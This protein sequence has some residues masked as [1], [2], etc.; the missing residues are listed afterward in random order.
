MAS[1]AIY[2]SAT[3][4]LSW[5]EYGGRLQSWSQIMGREMGA[6]A[7]LLAACGVLMVA[8]L[9]GWRSLRQTEAH[10]RV[11]WAFALLYALTLF[12]LLPITVDL[13]N[14]LT[15]AHQ[16]TDVGA[17]PL[18]DAPLEAASDPLVQAYASNYALDP[19]VYGPAWTILSTPATL[20]RHDVVGG[21]VYLKALA[22]LAFLGGSWLLERILR[23]L[24]PAE[25]LRGVYLFA[26]N[27]LVVLTAVG[28]GHNDIVMMALLLLATYLLL[29]ERWV[30]A[31]ALLAV[32]VWIKY[33]SAVLLPIFGLYAWRQI[34]RRQREARWPTVLQTGGAMA[35]VTA[36]A[37]LPFWS[38]EAFSGLVQRLLNPDNVAAGSFGFAVPALVLGLVLYAAVYLV[39]LW[40]LARGQG[41]L[42]E[43][44]HGGFV[45]LLLA[46]LF[47]AAR[48]QPWHLI[49]PASLAGL[50]DRRWAWPV[51]AGLAAVML[52]VQVWVEWGTPG[53]QM[54]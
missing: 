50:S 4:R 6:F 24:R 11:V 52:V 45:A 54:R 15:Q 13:F 43:T 20:G 44:L 21:L 18:V 30:W 35:L 29:R 47:G 37:F 34:G 46:F 10:R 36:A 7:L 53:L 33:M 1:E 9:V 12:W 51:V 23:Q 3:L 31:F 22:T 19:S 16:V 32:S 40:W 41:S 2:L 14:Y 38:P 26:W 17:N 48:A 42:Q 27:P 28:G 39:L 25:A 5:W 8:Y 49:W